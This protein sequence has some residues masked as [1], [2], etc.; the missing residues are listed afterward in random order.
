MRRSRL[1]SRRRLRLPDSI[2]GSGTDP[3]AG[4]ANLFDTGMVFAL[5]LF[6]AVAAHRNLQ[7]GLASETD[8]AVRAKKDGS[9]ELLFRKGKEIHRYQTTHTKVAG[10]GER[11][12]VAYKLKSGELVYV[13]DEGDGAGR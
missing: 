9:L 2:D 6:L 7:E 13:P 5:G 8:T 10:D 4:L 3:L 11:I 1:A 12:G